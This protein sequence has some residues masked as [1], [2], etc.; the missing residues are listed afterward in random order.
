MRVQ[1]MFC[2]IYVY[3]VAGVTFYGGLVTKDPTNS[4]F[5]KLA[6]TDYYHVRTSKRCETMLKG[7]SR[8]SHITALQAPR[9]KVFKH[10]YVLAVPKRLTY[11]SSSKLCSLMSSDCAFCLH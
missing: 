7:R 9:V 5:K 11:C 1:V 8:A 4:H 2:I 10:A 6:S 3:A